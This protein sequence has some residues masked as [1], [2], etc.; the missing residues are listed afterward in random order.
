MVVTTHRLFLLSAAS[1]PIGLVEHVG[2]DCCG[3][4]GI[5][6]DAT[7]TD[8]CREKISQWRPHGIARLLNM[9]YII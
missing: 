2:L 6:T 4:D 7:R 8:G 3:V 1:G 5:H 9:A